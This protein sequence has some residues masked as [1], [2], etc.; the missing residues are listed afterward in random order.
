VADVGTLPIRAPIK[1]NSGS[2]GKEEKVPRKGKPREEGEGL[3][4]KG[5]I[6]KIKKEFQE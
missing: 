3:S 5:G 2:P 4:P 6:E 1:T